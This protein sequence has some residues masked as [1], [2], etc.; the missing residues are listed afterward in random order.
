M[1]DTASSLVMAN[2]GLISIKEFAQILRKPESTIRTWKR[3][4]KIPAECFKV[5]GSTVF[6]RVKEMQEWLAQVA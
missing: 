6:I 5:I 2:F 4:G 3:R 1:T